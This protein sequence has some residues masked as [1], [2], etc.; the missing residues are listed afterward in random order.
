M[1]PERFRVVVSTVLIVGVN[2]SFPV[3]VLTGLL[4]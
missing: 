1:N 2:I 3:A 4:R